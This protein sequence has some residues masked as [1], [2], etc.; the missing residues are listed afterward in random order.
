M[1]NFPPKKIHIIGSVGSGKTTLA[2]ELS[3]K[4]DI[5]FYELD[6][7]VW[8][9]HESGDIRR[10]DEEIVKYLDTIFES[11]KWIIEG[12]HTQYWVSESL[13]NAE[14][15][16]LLD[17]KYSIRIYRIIKRFV[18]QKFGI[19][20]ANY[21]PTKEIFLKMFKWNKQFEEV[22][23]PKFLQEYEV[24]RNKLLIAPNRKFIENYLMSLYRR[25]SYGK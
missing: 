13:K 6:N 17:I 19:E 10:T 5:P 23:K 18:L 25:R 4:L 14:L 1:E 11:E 7:V 12:V 3:Q 21:K 15:I 20:K 9:R 8:N 22:I 2:K 16:I 24:Y